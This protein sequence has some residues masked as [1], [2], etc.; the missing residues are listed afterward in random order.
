MRGLRF[1]GGMSLAWSAYRVVAPL[2]GMLAPVARPF[3]MPSER[4]RWKER[5]GL[6]PSIGG[7]DVWIHAASLGETLGVRPLVDALGRLAPEA[8]M[9]LTAM[10]LAGRERLTS[11]DPGA[12]LAPM[13]APQIV[14]RFFD[15]VTPRRVILLETELWPHWLIEADR[16]SVPVVVASARL[17]E[18]SCRRYLRFGGEFRELVA[19]LANVQCQTEAD[20]DRWRRLGALAS[21]V[22]VSGNLKDD[23]L[24][25]PAASRP[26]ARLGLGLDPRRP[27]LVLGSLRPGEGSILARAWLRL[28]EALRVTWQV[29]AVARHAR[30]AGEI[31]RELRE[32]GIETQAVGSAT[33]GRPSA[34]ARQWLWEERPGVLASYY[35]AADV[36]FVGGSL[37]PLGGHN[38]LE[39]AACGVPVI[40]GP[41]HATQ[42]DAVQALR[43]HGALIVEST[44]RGVTEALGRWLADEP[45]RGSAGRAALAVASAR[46]GTAQRV[47]GHLV[48]RRLWPPR[49]E[50]SEVAR[51]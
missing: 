40:M 2:L 26:G 18:R 23:A 3:A 25:Q 44:D 50:K 51:R 27:L 8:T 31:R 33:A 29:V 48:A 28:P 7:C 6:G 45:A 46:R 21:R 32:R 41:H 10:T 24:P 30:A 34:A 43:S 39:P 1:G 5:M 20:A 14:R 17:S 36:A 42:R 15:R 11:I 37:V 9:F 22:E 19:R 4:E 16:R 35:S 47:A 49:E 12:A 13:D 38:P